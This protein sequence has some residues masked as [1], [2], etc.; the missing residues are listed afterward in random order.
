MPGCLWP[1]SRLSFKVRAVLAGVFSFGL[2]IAITG[3]VDRYERLHLLDNAIYSAT[4]YTNTV[5]EKLF[6]EIN[7][8]VSI[9]DNIRIALESNNGKIRGVTFYKISRAI[10]AVAGE[11]VRSVQLAPNGVIRYVYPLEGNVGILGL[12]ILAHHE[13]GLLAQQIVKNGKIRLTGP[14]N[15][16]QGGQGLIARQPLYDGEGGQGAFWGFATVVISWEPIAQML[17]KVLSGSGYEI[18]LRVIDGENQIVAAFFGDDELFETGGMLSM[19][20]MHGTRWQL[21]VYPMEGWPGFTWLS[22]WLWSLGLVLASLSGVLV[23]RERMTVGKLHLARVD[24]DKANVAKSSF[25]ANMSH[26]L[27]TPMNAILGFTQLMQN[28]PKHPLDAM[29]KDHTNQIL[30]AG[31]YLLGLINEVLDLSKIEAGKVSIMPEPLSLD[32]IILE[33]IHMVETMADK[34]SVRLIN[35]A[36]LEPS[37]NIRADYLRLREV[38]ANLLTNAIKYNHEGGQVTVQSHLMSGDR[39]RVSVVDNGYGIPKSK[40]ANVFKPFER[41]GRESSDIDG[42][43]IGLSITKELMRLMDGRI[44]FTSEENVGSTFWFEVPTTEMPTSRDS[45]FEAV[46]AAP[47]DWQILGPAGA[48]TYEAVY[49]EDNPANQL[50][51]KHIISMIPN[52]NLRISPTAEIG[53]HVIEQK[54]PDIVFMDLHLPGMS[55]CEA[56]QALKEMPKTR[57]IPVVVL[58]AEV[59]QVEANKECG[60]GFDAYLTKPL[61]IRHLTAVISDLIGPR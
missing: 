19:I 34:R 31:T 53:L 30:K 1:F 23:Y 22:V 25:L 52:L 46:T 16:I 20:E 33:S 54:I 17:G 13:Q 12:N 26:E 11:D 4:A 37:V 58:S 59:R 14:I 24:A 9:T 38:L 6:Y 40:Q 50:L 10:M 44:G 35:E 29:Q 45:A 15:L 28:L 32:D 48:K 57:G 39:L 5:H 18:A 43:G 2:V 8:R 21:A 36:H 42:T 56:L 61:S 41:L 47:V 27:R 55:G 7:R 3:F 51:M 49:I 60:T